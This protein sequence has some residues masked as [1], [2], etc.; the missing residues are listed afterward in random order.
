[1]LTFKKPK[2]IRKSDFINYFIYPRDQWFYTETQLTDYIQNKIKNKDVDV[3]EE[4]IEHEY[5]YL[6]GLRTAILNGET[7]DERDPK[8]YEGRLLDKKSR[9]FIALKYLRLDTYDFDELYSGIHDFNYLA[10]ETIKF[11]AKDNFVLFQPTFIYRNQAITKPDAL[12]KE[13]GKYTII[14]VKGTTKPKSKHL[15]DLIYQHHVINEVLKEFNQSIANYLLCV[16]KYAKETKGNVDFTLTE[17]IPLVK[18]GKNL[19]EKAEAQFPGILRY[20]D[21]AIEACRLARLDS[22][23]TVTINHLM[24]QD[25]KDLDNK[26][27]KI[28][29]AK[30]APLLNPE[31]FATIINELQTHTSTSEPSLLPD[32]EHFLTWF[33]NYPLLLLIRKYYFSHPRF[34]SFHWSGKVIKLDKQYE[35]YQTQQDL[36]E[37]MLCHYM[38]KQ[39]KDNI[40][41]FADFYNTLYTP[42][43]IGV[44]RTKETNDLFSQL[45]NQKVYFDFETIN[46]AIC[47]LDDTTPYTQV[48]TQVSIIENNGPAINLVIDPQTIR[49]DDLKKIIDQIYRG[50]NYSYVVYNKSFE[51]NRLKEM[52][53]LISE[54]EYTRK[55]ETINKNIFDLADFFTP[56]KDLITI[57]ELGGF[58]S[59]K[60]VLP[61][62]KREAP[63]V[64]HQSKAVDYHALKGIHHGGEALNQTSRR[65]F[66]LVD[67]KR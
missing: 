47:V 17:H 48:V 33:D 43:Q 5:D 23:S 10:D 52:A 60:N 11:L 54:N 67:D 28:Y 57:R 49:I 21:E 66:G 53:A 25:S 6:N 64:F 3:E 2:F 32:L 42:F 8:V 24:K 31:Y 16:V 38:V 4:F 45:K 29:D 65:F 30:I 15:V 39:N 61:I 19:S 63:D 44:Y 50:D 40:R 12:V 55:V 18:G 41:Y 22:A 35:A 37:T 7:I 26:K 13:N 58:Y 27:R 36:N 20:S 46:P 34:L 1:M 14:E 59:I 51:C 56:S 62:I 9:Q